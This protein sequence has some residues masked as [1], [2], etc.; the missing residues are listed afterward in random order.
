M[1]KLTVKQQKFADYYIELGN[2]SEAAVKAGY[3]K[4]TARVIGPEN[5]SKPA[6][7]AYIK[8]RMAELASERI[9][10]QQEILEL[11]TSIARGE[12]TEEVLIGVG[13]GAQTITEMDVDASNRIKAAELLGKRHKLWTDKVEVEGSAVVQFVDDIG[14]VS[15]E[16]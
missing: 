3:S 1:V 13:K 7:N 11:L 5:L 6:I 2:A 9:A 14:G 8:N 15:N 4:K 16:A 12:V 10:S